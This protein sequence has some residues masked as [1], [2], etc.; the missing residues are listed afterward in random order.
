MK[1]LETYL[2]YFSGF[3]GTHWED[4]LSTSKDDDAHMLAQRATEEPALEEGDFKALYEEFGDT[5]KHCLH[6]TRHF[7]AAFEKHI[8]M[9]AGFKVGLTF[10][11]LRSPEFYNFETDRIA[12]RIP[13]RSVSA[14]FAASEA[15]GHRLLRRAISDWFMPRDGCIPHYSSDPA[16]WLAK[17][18]DDWDRNELCVL[19]DPFVDPDIDRIVFDSFDEG[20]AY[21]AFEKS[22]DW[23]K[24]DRK[25]AALRRKRR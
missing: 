23:K 22:V 3:Y 7:C 2:P 18:V 20:Q 10:E 17:P 13:H 14:L 11:K 21:D 8:S 19:L 6:L 24:F 25:V 16:T 12:A 4:L 9:S 5:G 15:D 1:S